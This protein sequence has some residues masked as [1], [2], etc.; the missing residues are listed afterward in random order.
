MK[1]VFDTMTGLLLILMSILCS[2]DPNTGGRAVRNS[3]LT[4]K[5]S[6]EFCLFFIDMTYVPE[7]FIPYIFGG[8]QA[9]S[10]HF[11]R[12]PSKKLVGTITHEPLL[13]LH[14]NLVWLFSR[15]F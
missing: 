12:W 2:C 10:C 4:T 6:D 13:G 3:A 5:L 15:Y 11:S 1:S 9:I 8:Y 14:S 7:Q